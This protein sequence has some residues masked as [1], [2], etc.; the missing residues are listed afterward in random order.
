MDTLLLGGPPPATVEL[1]RAAPWMDESTRHSGHVVL[2][3]QATLGEVRLLIV[4]TPEATPGGPASERSQG[5][6]TATRWF[7]PVL[8]ADPGRGAEGTAAFDRLVVNA[9][10]EGLR[11]TTRRGNVIEFRGEPA[12][13][14][15][16]LPFDPGWCSNT[17]SLLD[18]GGTA[19]AHKAYRRIG[20]GT[21]EPELLRLMVG[22]GRTQQPV[23]EYAYVDTAT[24]R[25]EPLGVL[26]RYAE[27]E[28]LNVPLRAGIRALWP[29]LHAGTG[30]RA[31]VTES[32]Q[33]LTALL[34]AAG[35]FLRGFHQELAERLAPHPDFPADSFLRETA[36]KLG[37]L[38]PLILAD[39]R[40]PVEVR[41]AAA[42]GMARELAR[43]ADLPPR[44]WP[45]GPCHGDLHL[46]HVLC[47]ELPGG[48]W[49]FRLID[50][51]TPILDPAD[52]STAQSPWQDLAAL[53][54]GLEIFTADE[55]T[56][57]AADTLGM[58]PEDTCR[59]ALLQAAGVRPD[60]P[61][62][63]PEKLGELDRLRA[64]A[65]LW[66]AR[67]GDLLVDDGPAL[68]GHPAR[69]L[70]RL[71]RLIHEL[72]YA[73]AHDRAYHA[74]INLRHAVEA[75]ALPAAR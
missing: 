16:Q 65:R 19:H 49:D 70:F 54:R 56:D 62:W 1:L 51:S 40:I 34:R 8:D 7:V 44:P 14:E 15:G 13:Y 57:Q 23:G 36:G 53:T 48:I 37:A 4:G 5:A 58:D 41:E 38:T 74:A 30:P 22:S 75:S 43:I 46:S 52:P 26:Y 69:R 20:D 33:D 28:G 11:V 71:R 63:T 45:V 27:G 35:R 60:T 61:G 21:R 72:D 18:L 25:R 59:A 64:S 29:L 67:A 50:L 66:A 55:F 31:A 9:L 6:G 42:T 10:R 68:S 17:L 24:G 47:Q 2:L 73:Y 3:D 39:T 12:P 32:Q